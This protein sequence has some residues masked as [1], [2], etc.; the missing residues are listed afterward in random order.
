M[1]QYFGEDG[2]RDA[3]AIGNYHAQFSKL[4]STEAFEATAETRALIDANEDIP[5]ALAA[6]DELVREDFLEL[7]LTDV[8]GWTLSSAEVDLC[9][10]A[11]LA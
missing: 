7:R 10:L 6:L 11:W 2:R 4:S 3:E 8:G 1:L 9:V 5:Q